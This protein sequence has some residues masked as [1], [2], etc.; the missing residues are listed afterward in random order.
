MKPEGAFHRAP[1][2]LILWVGVA[3]VAGGTI[4]VL[5]VLAA[6]AMGFWATAAKGQGVPDMSGGLGV[7]AGAIA[8]VGAFVAQ[9]LSQRHKERMDQQ[10]R[11]V[12]P[13]APFVPTPPSEG[14]S[15]VNPHGGPD[16]P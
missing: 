9:V 4:F 8:S 2:P 13:N 15:A 16:T 14:G 11:G 5:A 10:A 7:L 12:A 3:L 1:R 6:I